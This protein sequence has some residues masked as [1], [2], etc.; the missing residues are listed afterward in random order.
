MPNARV[1]KSGRAVR[2]TCVSD[3][4]DSALFTGWGSHVWHCQRSGSLPFSSLLAIGELW[5]EL[6]QDDKLTNQ[7]VHSLSFHLPL[8]PTSQSS[9]LSFPSAQCHHAWLPPSFPTATFCGSQKQEMV[10]GKGDLASWGSDAQSVTSSHCW[11][12]PGKT[13]SRCHL[14]PVICTLTEGLGHTSLSP[15]LC[16]PV[17]LF[18]YM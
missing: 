12:R 1:P 6:V 18:K 2:K 17:V 13:V 4:T 15:P 14:L 8:P 9:Y 3:G 7:L 10:T 16:S 5:L 11:P